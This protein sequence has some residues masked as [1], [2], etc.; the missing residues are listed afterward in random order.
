[1]AKTGKK[2]ARSLTST[3]SYLLNEFNNIYNSYTNLQVD[4]Q[5]AGL[6]YMV[7]YIKES[8]QSG[9]K[10]DEIEYSIGDYV[11]SLVESIENTSI[12]DFYRLKTIQYVHTEKINIDKYLKNII[13]RENEKKA[14]QRANQKRRL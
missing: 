3:E 5:I 13:N 8:I 14:N 6:K 1:M 7:N 10:P 9:M 11:Q 12:N 4:N 2:G